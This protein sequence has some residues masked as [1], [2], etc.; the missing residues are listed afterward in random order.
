MADEGCATAECKQNHTLTLFCGAALSHS[1]II[2]IH[3]FLSEL[4]NVY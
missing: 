2:F 3:L 1:E 4:L